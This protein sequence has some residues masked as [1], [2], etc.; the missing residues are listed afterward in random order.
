MIL[1][2]NPQ[3]RCSTIGPGLAGVVVVAAIVTAT[4]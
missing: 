4:V 3:T 1:L 2:D